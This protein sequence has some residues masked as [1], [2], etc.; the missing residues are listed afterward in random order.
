[1]VSPVDLIA[2]CWTTAGDAVPLDGRQDSP[3]SLPERISAAS[4]A[5]FAG[6][7]IVHNDLANYLA[8]GNDLKELRQRLNDAGIRYVE[9]EFLSD[10]WLPAAQRAASDA[11]MR[12][13]LEA[14]EPLEAHHVKIGPDIEHMDFDLDHYAERFHRVADAFAGV[15]TSVALEFMPFA[16]IG[17]LARGVDVV[18]T[19]GHANGG[20]MVDLWHLMRG[21]GTL[22]ELSR[23]PLEYITGIELDDGGAEQI[24]TGYADTV[25]RRRLC[26]QGDF[27]VADFIRTVRSLGWEGPWG[28]EIISEE[29][30]QRPVP[31]AV[32]EAFT[33]TMAAFADAN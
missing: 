5:G 3:L 6:F 1:V 8:N 32:A 9:L 11:V 18:R 29:Y 25:L 21:S 23:V 16:N 26:G 31:Q 28:V 14:A 13:L 27:P 17:T 10:W 19:A 24:G 22:D 30:R 33:T 2:A 20:L 4:D 15:G 7:G 12:L